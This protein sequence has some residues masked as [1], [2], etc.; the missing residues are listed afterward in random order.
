MKRLA[1]LGLAVLLSCSETR[2]CRVTA[3]ASGQQ[4][5]ESDNLP[6]APGLANST[7]R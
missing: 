4:L 7:L 3:W 1:L 5:T 6:P 2:K